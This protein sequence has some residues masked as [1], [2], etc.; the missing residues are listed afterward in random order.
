MASQIYSHKCDFNASNPISRVNND[1]VGYSLNDFVS[2]YGAPEHL[3]YDGAAVQL[4]QHT[5]FQKS[6]QKYE[7]KTYVSA[8]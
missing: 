7:I 3:K 6:I 4:G 5:K 8:P 1:T 2:A